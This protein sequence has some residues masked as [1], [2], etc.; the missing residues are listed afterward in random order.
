[1]YLVPFMEDE[2]TVFLTTIIPSRKATKEYL[3]E[4][5]DDSAYSRRRSAQPAA[6]LDDS[7][8]HRRASTCRQEYACCENPRLLR[9][10]RARPESRPQMPHKK[11]GRLCLSAAGKPRRLLH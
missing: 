6:Q 11:D 3:G 8:K 5:I 4:E 7:E 1:M 2:H 10:K 9:D